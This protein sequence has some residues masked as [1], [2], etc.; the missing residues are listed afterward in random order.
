MKSTLDF[1]YSLQTFGMKFGLANIRALLRYINNPQKTYPTI[2][3]AGTNGKGSTSSMTAA[4]L[5]AA[6]YKVGLYTSPHLVKFNERI[7]INGKMISDHD[8][9]HY[10]KILKSEIQKVQA[11]FF[12]ATTAIAFQYF[13]DQQVDIAVIETGLGGRLDSTNII[14]PI[15]SVITTIGKDHTEQLGKH[16]SQIAFE[17][18]GIIKNRTPVV[19]GSIDGRAKSIIVAKAKERKSPILFSTKLQFPKNITLDLKGQHQLAN[20]RTAIGA[21]TVV[22]NAFVI[23][24]HAVKTGLEKASQL[25]GLR[26]RFEFIQDHPRLL[27][28]V[29]H[30]PHG[31]SSLVSAVKK[32]PKVKTVIIFAVMKD[33]NYHAMLLRLKKVSTTIILTHLVTSRSMAVDALADVCIS[34]GFTVIVKSDISEAVTTGKKLA[35]AKGLLIITG[36]HYLA[37][38]VL[39]YLSKK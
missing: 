2:H 28:D 16:I 27:L 35:G 30:N 17:K 31:I 3:V 21:I 34:L 32:L 5:T 26:A 38:D 6:G 23:G 29:A 15:V 39:S 10:T 25:S 18:A 1:L 8:V 19:L 13:A 37:G 11:T 36:S 24:D 7:R 22:S 9:V 20:A 4:I 33:K 12:E 14:K